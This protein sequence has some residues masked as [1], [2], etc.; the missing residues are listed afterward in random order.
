M[1]L[2]ELRERERER[3]R[4][5][6]V[7]WVVRVGRVIN[8]EGILTNLLLFYSTIYESITSRAFIY[9]FNYIFGMCIAHVVGSLCYTQS[10]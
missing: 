1:N 8:G 4:Q 6:C 10:Q 2:K 7:E 9:F 5:R 3:E